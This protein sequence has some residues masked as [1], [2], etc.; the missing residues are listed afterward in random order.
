MYYLTHILNIAASH[1]HPQP[2]W[3]WS[4]CWASG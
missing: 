4:G 2:S 1:S 3:C